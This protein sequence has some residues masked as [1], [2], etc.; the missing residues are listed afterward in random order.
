MTELATTTYKKLNSFES[1]R[2]IN[3]RSSVK[4]QLSRALNT[5]QNQSNFKNKNFPNFNE[6]INEVKKSLQNQLN[7]KDSNLLGAST[8]FLISDLVAEEMYL[9][10]DSSL[11]NYLFHRYR[12]EI[13]PQKR[14]LDDNPPYVQIEPSSICN[15][16]CKFCYQTD[17]T[18]SDIKSAHMGT[19]EFE[20][21]K[22]IIDILSGKT[23][24][25]SLASRGEPFICKDLPRMLNYSANKFLN[26]KINTN[27]SLLNEEKI[28]ALLSGGAKTIV[29]SIDA[30]TKDLYKELRVN[31]K[32]ENII[33]R[34]KLFRKIKE[35]EYH[36]NNVIVRVSG[37]YVD[38][39]QNM[40]EMVK[41]WGEF[42]DQ[43]TFVKYN[44]W[45]N[46]YESPLSEVNNHCSD[47]W[48]RIFIWYDGQLN[49]CD[50]DYKSTLSIGRIEDFK[51]LKNIWRSEN[52][53]SLRNMHCNGKRN[54]VSP[55]NKCVVV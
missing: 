30:P 50:T 17:E 34:L 27:A 54:D 11:V 7:I 53:E 23:E 33:K 8:K 45:E 32:I 16:R 25:I 48:R 31:G 36:K 52:Y 19:M 9:T 46:V 5:L 13:F 22:K 26:L 21:Y 41:I 55:C 20:T 28:H 49:P 43:I 40:D 6:V 3:K 14:I 15:Y 42:V 29:F 10:S 12:Y 38:Q 47:L 24:F 51:N 37:V 2:I 35:S 1:T 44:P 39:R 4:E 18:F